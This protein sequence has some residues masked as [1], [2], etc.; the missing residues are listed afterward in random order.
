MAV[1][2]WGALIDMID[3]KIGDCYNNSQFFMTFYVFSHFA[4]VFDDWKN[5]QLFSRFSRM[6]GNPVFFFI[7]HTHNCS[8]CVVKRG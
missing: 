4:C 7:V 6:R 8:D 5:G 1:L 2:F 3:R